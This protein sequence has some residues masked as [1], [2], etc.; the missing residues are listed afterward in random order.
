MA[1]NLALNAS[2]GRIWNTKTQTSSSGLKVLIDFSI[3]KP[4][5]LAKQSTFNISGDIAL[6]GDSKG[7][8]TL[9]NFS[10]NW[11]STIIRGCVSP[12]SLAIIPGQPDEIAVGMSTKNIEIYQ[13]TG[14][15]V[16]SLRGHRGPVIGISVNSVKKLLLSI[17]SDSCIIWNVETWTRVRSLYAQAAAFIAG[18]F[19]PNMQSILTC[20]VDGIIFEWSLNSYELVR[21]FIMNENEPLGFTFSSDYELVIGVGKSGNLHVWKSENP[22]QESWALKLPAELR[23]IVKL[24]WLRGDIIACIGGNGQFYLI[25]VKTSK[26]ETKIE[27]IDAMVNFETSGNGLLSGVLANGNVVIYDINVLLAS[28]QSQTKKRLDIGISPNL[29]KSSDKKDNQDAQDIKPLIA[30]KPANEVTFKLPALKKMLSQYGE[31]PEK[32]RIA[33]W[34]NL[35]NLPSNSN[36][37]ERLKSRG[38]HPSQSS[39]EKR[40]PLKEKS[41]ISPLSVV[42]SALSYWCPALGEADF[43]PSI[44][45]PFL[46]LSNG[47]PLITFEITVSLILYWF[48]HWFENFPEPPIK[49]LV[50]IEDVIKKNDIKLFEHIRNLGVNCSSYIWPVLKNVFT[51]VMTR[52]EF[53]SLMDHI[54]CEK[55]KPDLLIFI[56]AE[57]FMYFRP[58]IMTINS[59]EDFNYFLHRQNPINIQKLVKGALRLYDNRENI[60]IPNFEVRIPLPI[61]EYPLFTNYPDFSVQYKAQVRERLLLEE[62]ELLQ[63]NEHIERINERLTMLEEQESQFRKE[64][65]ALLLA[66]YERRKAAAI[67]DQVRMQEKL[68]LDREIREKRLNQIKKIENTVESSLSHQ[69]QIRKQELRRLEEEIARK[70]EEDRYYMQNRTEE[71]ALSLLEFKATQRLLEL[72]RVRAGEE[73][74]RKLRLD[75]EN[76]EREQEMK[77]RLTQ[78]KWHIDDEER[79]LKLEIMRENKQKELQTLSDYNDRRR[80]EIQQHITILEKELKGQDI[81]RERRIRQVSEEELLRH[82]DQ[83]QSM[84][85]KQELLR[86]HEEKYFENLLNEEKEYAQRKTDERLRV[87]EEEKEKQKY[88]MQRNRKEI[89]DLEKELERKILNDKVNEMRHMTEI[90][91]IEEEKQLQEMLLKIEEERRMQRQLQQDLEFKEKEIKERAAFQKALRGNEE[92]ALQDQRESFNQLRLQLNKES[93]EISAARERAHRLKMDTIIKQ[94]EQEL[95][96]I[97]KRSSR[98]FDSRGFEPNFE[99]RKTELRGGYEPREEGFRNLETRHIESRSY[100]PRMEEPRQF[101]SRQAEARDY[102]PHIEDQRQRAYEPIYEEPRARVYEPRLEEPRTRGYEPRLEEPRIRGYEPRL[103]EP[104]TRAYEPIYEEQLRKSE[105]FEQP[106]DE[107]KEIDSRQVALRAYDHRQFESRADDRFPTYKSEQD[108]RRSYQ[109]SPKWEESS[110]RSWESRSSSQVSQDSHCPSCDCSHSSRSSGCSCECMSENSEASIANSRDQ[111]DSS[112]SISESGSDFSGSDAPHGRHT[113]I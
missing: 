69:E 12:T 1:L 21:K 22:E 45:F 33:I 16:S 44:V 27:N 68:K 91:G 70:Q 84:K 39:L 57:Y 87:L 3:T 2:S 92:R 71:E 56:A 107:D 111:I 73:S 10:Q 98:G 79:R 32:H 48:Q 93:E 85:R 88:E 112:S 97:E 83:I 64:Q 72:M 34:S 101:E 75:T 4:R 106:I 77:D 6:I 43:M 13:L 23:G 50:A 65:E 96:E 103:E 94:R 100:D 86:E 95:K 7:T 55:S 38:L 76:W 11:F 47:D 80:V 66:E 15:L 5:A 46:K 67:E 82:E 90:K 25:N 89:E 99:A 40:F 31:F 62:N 20:F 53:I 36:E 30:L 19:A 41:L 37:F 78:N 28:S 58:T 110:D 26:I 60:I 109:D 59:N 102:E 63:K 108:I 105:D 54:F 9:F 14:R 17:S 113:H 81:E 35:L 74:M 49:Y 24:D 61:G 51:E 18:K 42:M 29:A 52:E 104:R 8:I